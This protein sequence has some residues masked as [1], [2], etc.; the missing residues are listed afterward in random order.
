MAFF[1][2]SNKS[3]LKEF[4]SLIGILNFAYQVEAPGRAFCRRLIDATFNLRKPHH[5]T[6]IT[7]SM[8]DDI[9][10]WLLFL[11]DYKGTTVILDQF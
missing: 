2:N 11:K 5:R 10:V 1:I 6:R 3:T 8:K 7:K 4:Q 9:N